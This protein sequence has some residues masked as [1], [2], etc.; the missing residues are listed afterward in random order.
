MNAKNESL[1]RIYQIKAKLHLLIIC[2]TYMATT[3]IYL[4]ALYLC[5]SRGNKKRLTL[6][7][8]LRFRETNGLNAT[9]VLL[10]F[11]KIDWLNYA[12]LELKC[13]CFMN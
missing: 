11:F 7:F 12:K 6:M 13:S 2:W 5:D 9:Y 10:M 1:L 4:L 8:F 3:H